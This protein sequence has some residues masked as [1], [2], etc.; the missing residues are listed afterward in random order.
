MSRTANQVRGTRISGAERKESIIASAASQFAAKGFTGTKTRAI[1]EHAGVSEALLFKHFPSKNELYAAILAKES[2]IPH[3]LN[4]L[5]VLADQ[6][7]D[8]QV[9]LYIA[10]TIVRQARMFS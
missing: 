8:E 10:R 2:P 5:K 4:E 7:D 6:Q 1:A 9:F 3:I